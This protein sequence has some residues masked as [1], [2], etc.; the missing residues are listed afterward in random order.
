MCIKAHVIIVVITIIFG[1][2]VFI[3]IIV[4]SVI[5]VIIVIIYSYYIYIM[6]LCVCV[7]SGWFICLKV[8]VVH[9]SV[10]KRVCSARKINVL[11]DVAGY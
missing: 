9:F 5:I 8:N 11:R 6:C 1:I 4:I 10:A 2:I 7:T 3:V